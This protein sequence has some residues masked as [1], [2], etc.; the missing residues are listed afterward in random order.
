MSM[1]WVLHQQWR[2]ADPDIIVC[3]FVNSVLWQWVPQQFPTD[4][5]VCTFV[6][7]FVHCVH[8]PVHLLCGSAEWHG[9]V[10]MQLLILC[11]QLDNCRTDKSPA[12]VLP[13]KSHKCCGFTPP[14]L[15]SC[16]RCLDPILRGD[17]ARCL[18]SIFAIECSVGVFP[19]GGH[20]PCDFQTD[21]YFQKP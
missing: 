13:A 9:K 18:L 19:G 8:I 11:A 3:V 2:K 4:I 14:L 15:T 12:R 20:D 1:Q 10:L 7:C 6:L 21:I 17:H 5:F 16:S